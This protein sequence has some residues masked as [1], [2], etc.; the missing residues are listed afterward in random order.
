MSRKLPFI[1]KIGTS[2]SGELDELKGVCNNYYVNEYLTKH[3]F[4]RTYVCTYVVEEDRVPTYEPVALEPSK[5]LYVRKFVLS[6]QVSCR[7]LCKTCH[8]PGPIKGGHE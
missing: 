3:G 7:R 8:H 4:V 1:K 2:Q 6:D 5:L